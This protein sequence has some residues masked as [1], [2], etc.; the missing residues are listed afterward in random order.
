MRSVKKVIFRNFADFSVCR[1][2]PVL[3][4]YFNKVAGFQ[5]ASFLKK[6]LT[7]VLSC[8]IC[9]TF[10]NTY[11][12]EHLQMTASIKKLFLRTL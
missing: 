12:E 9:E 7:Q 1:K 2:T 10:K 11:F 6:T 5:P 3:Q 8:E 4:S